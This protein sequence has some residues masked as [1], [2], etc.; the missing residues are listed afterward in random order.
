M[1][2]VRPLSQRYFLYGIALVLCLGLALLSWQGLLLR[3]GMMYLCA[4]TFVYLSVNV[5]SLSESWTSFYSQMYKQ[6]KHLS[7]T[8]SQPGKNSSLQTDEFVYVT[9]VQSK[10]HGD[11]HSPDSEYES[12]DDA[13]GLSGKLKLSKLRSRRSATSYESDDDT[14]A[15][16][17]ESKL[18]KLRFRMSASSDVFFSSPHDNTVLRDFLISSLWQIRP[19]F[20]HSFLPGEAVSGESHRYGKILSG[21][22]SQIFDIE[23]RSLRCL[24]GGKPSDTTWGEVLRSYVDMLGSL[25]P[26]SDTSPRNQVLLVNDDDI[27]EQNE[28]V[29]GVGVMTSIFVILHHIY[30]ECGKEQ[31]SEQIKAT[32]H[33]KKE[34][35]KRV[36]QDRHA[37]LDKLLNCKPVLYV[38]CMADIYG[39]NRQGAEATE[40]ATVTKQIIDIVKN[41][42]SLRYPLLHAYLDSE[43]P[44][45]ISLWTDIPKKSG[46]DIIASVTWRAVLQANLT[47]VHNESE[48]NDFVAGELSACAVAL[49]QLMTRL[50]HEMTLKVSDLSHDVPLETNKHHQEMTSEAEKLSSLVGHHVEIQ[51]GFQMDGK[52]VKIYVDSTVSDSS[53]PTRSGLKELLKQ[54]KNDVLQIVGDVSDHQNSF[55]KHGEVSFSVHGQDPITILSAPRE[56]FIRRNAAALDSNSHGDAQ[57]NAIVS[58]LYVLN[59]YY[60]ENSDEKENYLTF[61][62]LDMVSSLEL[63]YPGLGDAINSAC[64]PNSSFSCYSL[65][66]I[67]PYQE[68]DKMRYGEHFCSPGSTG[69]SDDDECMWRDRYAPGSKS[70]TSSY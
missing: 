57:Y 12:D 38:P 14:H 59:T 2:M 22:H 49:C 56:Q 45:D 69:Q 32:F 65:V 4:V 21:P 46:D 26:P 11:D 60:Y 54:I 53:W 41:V 55:F 64:A 48:K 36:F 30:D 39:D 44:G 9:P 10:R 20:D 33:E 67:K 47:R 7:N 17:G 18:S 23:M 1:R 24:S 63:Y 29:L 13:H 28:S 27:L 40:S 66:D 37:K 62:I 16:S 31:K 68:S 34:D 50:F 5:K 42:L 19:C 15:L 6:G 52:P 61:P 70:H 51:R 58:I 3:F 25:I 43:I 35:L 8:G